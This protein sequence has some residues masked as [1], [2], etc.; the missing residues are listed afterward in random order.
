MPAIHLAK[1]KKQ[2]AELAD[3]FHDPPALRNALFEILD[4][5]ADRTRRH[6]QAGEPPPLRTAHNVPA[7]VIRQIVKELSTLVGNYPD[8]GLI[9]CDTLWKQ[10]YLEENLIA[11]YLLGYIRQE[12]PEPVL[13]RVHQW[14]ESKPES[15][16]VQAILEHSLAGIRRD[17]PELYVRT[18]EEWVTDTD[19]YKKQI[20]LKA[21]LTL[22]DQPG[23]DDLAAIFRWINPLIR[24]SPTEIR[25]EIVDV[26]RV[27]ARRSP[28]ETAYNMRRIFGSSQ[29]NNHAA[30]FMR[31]TLK[32]FPTH[33]QLQLR[34][35]L[36]QERSQF[37]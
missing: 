12:N 10:T 1:L 16:L 15:R 30:W 22:I 37:H 3:Y 11:A 4:H 14:L 6:G 31:Q 5:Y 21:M 29:E 18:L 17:T 8:S 27:L 23:F 25:S 28:I 2:A 7:P 36:R 19:V 34:L 26:L 33:I 9:L 13:E 24:T 35:A 32:Y 20:G